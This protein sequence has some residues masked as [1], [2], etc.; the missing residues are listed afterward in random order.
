M[1]QRIKVILVGTTHSGNIGSAARAMKTMGLSQLCLV[2]PECDIDAQA[3][4]L[5]AGAEDILQKTQ[6]YSDLASAAAD[7]HLVLGAS[8][9]LRH[10]QQTLLE[11]QAAAQRAMQILHTPATNVAL[12]FGRERVGLTNDE[13]LQCNNHVFIPTN[14]DYRSLNLA[15][16]VQ[17]VCYEMRKAW[18][19]QTPQSIAAP[20]A[21]SPRPTAQALQYFFQQTEI[22]YTALGFIK[23]RAVMDKLQHLYQRA[24]LSESELN[25]LNGMLA[26]VQKVQG[27][28]ISTKNAQLF[29]NEQKVDES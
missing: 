18:L 4:A 16:A 3:I 29:T 8:A 25:L 2:A 21:Q 13:L 1:L 7:C 22:F 12:V 23:N 15:M 19:E 11:P 9:R 14:P 27:R 26:T 6:I 28:N 10:L 17:I 24:D 20:A 5:S